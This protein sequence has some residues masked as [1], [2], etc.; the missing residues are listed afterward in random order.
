MVVLNIALQPRAD[1]AE[2]AQ[3]FSIEQDENGFFQEKHY[4]I[5]P[6]GTLTDGIY[7][8]GCCQGPKDIPDSVAQAIGAA[9]KALA[10]VTRGEVGAPVEAVASSKE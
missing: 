3:L 5:D 4:K 9:A 7:M 6:L 2:V 8:A 10:L 1:A